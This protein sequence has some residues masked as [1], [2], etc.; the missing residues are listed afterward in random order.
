MDDDILRTGNSAKL[1]FEVFSGCKPA[2]EARITDCLEE[3]GVIV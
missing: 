2:G 3:D 1:C